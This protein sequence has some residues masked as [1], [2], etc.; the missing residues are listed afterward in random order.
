MRKLNTKDVFAFARIVKASG[1]RTELKAIIREISE[2][3]DWNVEDI[4][5]ESVLAIL[6]ALAEKK[7]ETAICE[8]LAGP[9]EM[10][11]EE[12]QNL[13]LN[14]LLGYMRRMIEEN[15]L[16]SFFSYVSGIAGR[17]S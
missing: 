1:M 5:M 14:D 10:T 2:R 11:A 6:E 9:F 13:E 4:G 7:S 15:D 8:M 16:R 17:K 12:V 3:E